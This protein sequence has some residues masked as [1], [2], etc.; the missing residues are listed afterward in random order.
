M[1]ELVFRLFS[2][3]S[4]TTLRDTTAAAVPVLGIDSD[5]G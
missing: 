4:K 5:A 1:D 3:R 2:I